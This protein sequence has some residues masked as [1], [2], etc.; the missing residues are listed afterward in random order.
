LFKGWEQVVEAVNPFAHVGMENDSFETDIFSSS[1]LPFG[2]E[3]STISFKMDIS[4]LDVVSLHPD[5]LS[6]A[7]ENLVSLKFAKHEAKKVAAS[8]LA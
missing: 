4:F 3:N 7:S 6:F 5:I 2:C 8:L 1:F